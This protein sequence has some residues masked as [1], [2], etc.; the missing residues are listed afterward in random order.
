VATWNETY[1]LLEE[2]A[3]FH[4]KTHARREQIW[5]IAAI[6]QT[7]ED[8]EIQSLVLDL[9]IWLVAKLVHAQDQFEQYIDIW[10]SCW[11]MCES[12]PLPNPISSTFDSTSESI[13]SSSFWSSHEPTPELSSTRDTSWLLLR[14][15]RLWTN[16][17]FPSLSTLMPYLLVNTYDR[18]AVCDSESIT[19]QWPDLTWLTHAVWYGDVAMTWWLDPDRILTSSPV[20]K[21]TLRDS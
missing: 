7:T 4:H 5:V 16:H 3:D 18:L 8:S 15:L 2:V 1:Q 10:L 12:S 14:Y 6:A 19:M 20:F 9:V 21:T 17:F 11:T 13:S